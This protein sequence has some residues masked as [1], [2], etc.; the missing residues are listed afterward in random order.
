M[1]NPDDTVWN[2]TL[3]IEISRKPGA[4]D[5]RLVLS[6][7]GRSGTL[8]RTWRS[9]S[10]GPISLAQVEDFRAAVIQ[11]VDEWWLVGGAQLALF[12]EAFGTRP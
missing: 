11:A 12:D 9:L 6:V 2:G 10:T 7:P 4:G 8:T 3:C 1:E 5:V